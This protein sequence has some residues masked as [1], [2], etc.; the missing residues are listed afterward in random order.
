MASRDEVRL[1]SLEIGIQ[2][3]F[4]VHRDSRDKVSD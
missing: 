3:E 1:G 4:V 2:E